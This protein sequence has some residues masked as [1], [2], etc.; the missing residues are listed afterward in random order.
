M[1]AATNSGIEVISVDRASHSPIAPPSASPAASS[2]GLSIPWLTSAATTATN[3]PS[4]A[5][6]LPPRAVRGDASRL[7]PT[8]KRLAATR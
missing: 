2:T 7:S 4:D 8:M 1:N 5:I 6:R 3:I